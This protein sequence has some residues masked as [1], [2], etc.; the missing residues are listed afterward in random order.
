MKAF[1]FS[2]DAV[3]KLAVRRDLEARIELARWTGEL[4]RLRNQE[5]LLTA[6]LGEA[7][8]EAGRSSHTTAMARPYRT[9]LAE[10]LRAVAI[11]ASRASALLADARR[12]WI[13]ARE[14]KMT[15]EGLRERRREAHDA[16]ALQAEQRELEELDRMRRAAAGR[17]ER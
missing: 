8:R 9:A 16:A 7:E 2:L 6:A 13:A 3:L 12:A 11:E 5:T 4:S 17:S 15:F 14:K 1:R 10:R